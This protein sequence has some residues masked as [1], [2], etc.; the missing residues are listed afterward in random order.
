MQKVTQSNLLDEILNNLVTSIS[1]GE[2]ILIR[3][4]KSVVNRLIHRSESGANQEIEGE[5]PLESNKARNRHESVNLHMVVDGQ[6]KSQPSKLRRREPGNEA[7]PAIIPDLDFEAE[8]TA[9]NFFKAN[10]TEAVRG[11]FQKVDTVRWD[12]TEADWS[13]EEFDFEPPAK[14]VDYRITAHSSERENQK[15]SDTDQ[16]FAEGAL[17]RLHAFALQRRWRAAASALSKAASRSA[18]LSKRERAAIEHLLN[19]ADTLALH[20]GDSMELRKWLFRAQMPKDCTES[21]S[22][23]SRVANHE[24]ATANAA[25]QN[26]KQSVKLP[27]EA[28]RPTQKAIRFAVLEVRKTAAGRNWLSPKSSRALTRIGEKNVKL[29]RSER[30]ALNH[31]LEHCAALPELTDHVTNLRQ[32]IAE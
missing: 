25:G 19:V 16:A 29:S 30:N 14:H 4:L 6:S 13:L 31:L 1:S 17:E 24:V 5:E 26:E 15:A 7:F 3:K 22:P 28:R 21:P 32:A 2:L 8:T 18:K 10:P 20:R 23:E 11:T 27:V 9:E 12:H